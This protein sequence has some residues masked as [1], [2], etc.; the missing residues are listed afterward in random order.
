VLVVEPGVFLP[1]PLDA[2][3]L[4]QESPTLGATPGELERRVGELVALGEVEIRR[5][6]FA[7]RRQRR[8]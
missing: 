4:L 7:L 1:P 8:N 3:L 2:L 5:R 6:G